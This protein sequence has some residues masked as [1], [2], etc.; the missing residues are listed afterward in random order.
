MRSWCLHDGGSE[1]LLPSG[2]RRSPAAPAE[3]AAPL[4]YPFGPDPAD[5]VHRIID[6]QNDAYELLKNDDCYA[7]VATGNLT[8][9][10]PQRDISNPIDPQRVVNRR[11]VDSLQPLAGEPGAIASVPIPDFGRGVLG[12]MTVYP[13]FH[14][15]GFDTSLF[16][17]ETVTLTAIPTGAQMRALALLH[18]IAHLIGS[19]PVRAD[20]THTHAA[21]DPTG[22]VFN[23]A[24][25]VKCLGAARFNG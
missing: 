12:T 16:K 20:G 1:H 8:G 9:V 10:G 7:F 18:E 13:L 11:P 2:R 22:Q 21:Q 4:P 17:L 3:P 19:N 6:A 23:T 15:L 5:N 14:A 25:L 24:L